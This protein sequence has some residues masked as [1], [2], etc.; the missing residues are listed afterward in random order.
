ME[1]NKKITSKH[2]TSNYVNEKSVK[3]NKQKMKYILPIKVG[4]NTC[5]IKRIYI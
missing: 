4:Y 3:S 1:Y 2:K 5:W